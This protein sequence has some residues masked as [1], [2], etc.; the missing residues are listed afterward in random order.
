MKGSGR[1]RE[2]RP[3]GGDYMR[4]P[5]SSTPGFPEATAIREALRCGRTGCACMRPRG[6]VHCPAHS[7]EHPSLAVDVRGSRLL[8]HCR[9]G[10]PQ[11]AVLAA[12][13]ARGL[14]PA[15]DGTA[16][17]RVTEYV[18]RAPDGTSLA[19]HVRED[20]GGGRKRFFWRLPDGRKGLDGLRPVDML[21]GIE[22]ISAADAIVLL[23]EGERATDALHGAGVAA[24]GTVCGAAATPSDSVL[25]HLVRDGRQIVL[26]P[27]ADPQGI[28]HMERIAQVLHRLGAREV[29]MIRPPEGVPA[30]WDAADAAAEGRDV[31]A[32]IAGAEPWC[33]ADPGPALLTAGDILAAADAPDPDWLIDGLV[34]TGGVVLLV[35]RPKSGKS[36]FARALAVAVAQGRPFLE[37]QVRHGPVLLLSLEDRPRDVGRHLRFL[38][39]TPQD[40]LLVATAVDRP[41]RLREWVAAHRPT[42]VVVDT[43]GRLVRLKDAGAYAEVV[44][45]LE[46][47]LRLARESGAALVLLHHAPKGSDGR[48]PVDA[49]LG[50]TAFAGTADVI[51]HLKRAQDGARTLASVQRVGEDLEESVLTLGQDGWPALT[52]TKRE[53]QEAQTADA[54]LDLLRLR[55]EGCT[56]R[57]IL[58]AVGGEW[59]QKLRALK[60]LAREGKVI[61]EGAGRRGDPH[62][63][64]LPGDSL[65]RCGNTPAQ[66]NNESEKRLEPAPVLDEFVARDP[67]L[68]TSDP[69]RIRANR[70]PANPAGTPGGTR[71][72]A[73]GLQG[74]GSEPARADA[75]PEPPPP[76]EDPGLAGPEAGREGAPIG[77]PPPEGL[78]CPEHG[79][80]LP[81][82]AVWTSWGPRCPRCNRSLEG[83]P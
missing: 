41:E 55:E 82:R 25:G 74:V 76:G 1:P 39:L 79:P 22:R 50:S 10:C 56:T 30:G 14:W 16:L 48:D 42:L 26:W 34:P 68:E 27:D 77:P 70:V 12:L 54:I 19:I 4:Q 33:P 61:Q 64:R 15:N 18:I 11:G 28:R 9:A 67:G 35:G 83:R 23:V 71:A 69:Q 3:P 5:D 45:A 49:P 29:R 31:R 57:E 44:G 72:S 43:V 38:G 24:V 51:L 81:V 36:T 7:D 13:R 75:L 63:Y 40:P 78:W 59:G 21:Y 73:G 80:V 53:A 6:P 46:G 37:R 20:L 52:G 58:E 17:R 8:L 62:R 2:G 32:L 65:F 66:R 60:R 47:V